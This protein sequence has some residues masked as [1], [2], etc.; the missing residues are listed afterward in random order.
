M[1]FVCQSSTLNGRVAIPASKSHTIRAVAIAAMAEGTSIVHR[2]LVSADTVSAAQAATH[3]GAAVRFEKES[4][5]IT[6]CAGNLPTHD[7]EI[8]VGNSGTTLRI[9]MGLSSLST[10]ATITL[11]GDKQIQ[12]RPAGPLVSALNG[13]GANVVS[14]LNNGCAPFVIKGRLHGGSIQLESPTS[15]YLTSLL[16]SCPLADADAEIEVLTLNEKAYVQITLDWLAQQEITL[17]HDGLKSF[18]IPGNQC[19]RSFERVIPADFSSASFFLCAGALQGNSVCCEGL[20]MHDS[21]P[22]KQV[23]SYLE[24]MGADVRRE[25]FSVHVSAQKLKGIEIDMN[26]TPDA[27]PVM[28]VL[29]CFAEGE[30]RLRN[31]AHARIKETDRIAVMQQELSKMG[32]DIEELPDGLVIRQS[33][34]H[35]AN[36]DGHD[37]HRVVMALA[38]AGMCTE[39]ETRIA[40]AEAAGV[41]FPDFADCMAQLGG[42]IREE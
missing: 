21:Q 41:T 33:S 26:E 29:G 9:F 28:A 32:A 2:P 11:T 14:L 36:V 24:A 27:L 16:L 17:L 10:E 12:R 42:N 1:K 8:D 3:L 39:G 25:D 13:L 4:W 22:D 38:L 15:Q 23:V 20:D 40:T 19:Y 35:A 37:D 30:T 34:L 6:G 31:V 18:S 5:E 7:I